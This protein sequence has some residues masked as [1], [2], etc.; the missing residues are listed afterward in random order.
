MKFDELLESNF[1]GSKILPLCHLH[2]VKLVIVFLV[3]K[4]W[5][6]CVIVE[7]DE[8]GLHCEEG[9]MNQISESSVFHGNFLLKSVLCAQKWYQFSG[10]A[11]IFPFL[12]KRT[13]FFFSAL[14][15]HFRFQIFCL[16]H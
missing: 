9:E 2:D 11:K 6:Q 4:K 10:L 1:I 5:F 12:E 14:S 3:V 15:F 8:A 13:H 16:T 7:T